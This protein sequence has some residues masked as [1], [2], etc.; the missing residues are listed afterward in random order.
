LDGGWWPQSRDLTV[1]LPD[2]VD[3]FP[4]EEGRVVGATFSPPD[5]EPAPSRI[6][7]ASGFVNAGSFPND[8][9]HTIELRMSGHITLR[10]LVVPPAMTGDQAE[11]AL[12]AAA[13]PGYS[14]TAASLLEIVGEDPDVDPRDH[15]HDGPAT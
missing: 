5:W 3:H 6:R 10:L 12:L 7:V 15:W 1:E 4:P 8:D 9:T 14:H 2:L 11:E 13:T